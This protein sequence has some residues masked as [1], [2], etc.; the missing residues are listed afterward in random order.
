[1]LH[2]GEEICDVRSVLFSVSVQRER[3]FCWSLKEC[4][5][6]FGDSEG[7][8]HKPALQFQGIVW[9]CWRRW[10]GLAC[11]STCARSHWGLAFGFRIPC[12]RIKIPVRVSGRPKPWQGLIQL[13][14]CSSHIA[15]AGWTRHCLLGSALS[16][17][18][19]ANSSEQI[20]SNYS[21]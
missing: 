13:F 15:Q 9:S 17:L 14:K 10:F 16:Y 21:R 4:P 8:I 5:K 7:E 11:T 12:R 1:M 2:T 6:A 19:F 3:D 20:G 18:L